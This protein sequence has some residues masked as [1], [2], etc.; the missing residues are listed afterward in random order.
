MTSDPERARRLQQLR[1]RRPSLDVAAQRLAERPEW[2]RGP[3][4]AE[5]IDA[6]M[7]QPPPGAEPL[8]ALARR[9]ERAPLSA[10]LLERLRG[11]RDPGT[12]AQAAWL[13]K[14]VL[15]EEHRADAIELAGAENES[16]QVRRWLVEALDR[17]AFAAAAGGDELGELVERLARHEHPALREGAVGLLTSLPRTDRSTALLVRL[18][19]DRDPLVAA[20]A[21]RALGGPPG[22]RVVEEHTRA[23]L[24]DHS[25]AEVRQAA[26]EVLGADS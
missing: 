17:L 11:A 7:E 4:P 25:S 10:A 1:A 13:L 26:R 9:Y 19:G 24:L 5:L 22:S 18:L 21:A 15:A 20:G 12:R 16:P 6:L 23:A 2:L 3:P 8:L 14:G